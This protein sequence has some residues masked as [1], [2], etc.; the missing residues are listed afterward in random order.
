[1]AGT[2]WCL[3]ESLSPLLNRR[4]RLPR[5]C[6]CVCTLSITA[7]AKHPR[8]ALLSCPSLPTVA[9]SVK[10]NERCSAVR[11]T[12]ARPER[13]AGNNLLTSDLLFHHLMV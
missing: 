6:R 5:C 13:H 10:S 4:C 11:N 7:A 8:W 3:Y 1:M 12:P 2:S 9:R